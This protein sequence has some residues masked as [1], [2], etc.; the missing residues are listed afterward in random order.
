[1]PPSFFQ[2]GEQILNFQ[3]LVDQMGVNIGR[4]GQFTVADILGC[5][6]FA[7]IIHDR[8][9]IFRRAQQLGN[10]KID[11]DKPVKNQR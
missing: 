8:G 6:V 11:I 3:A 10:D 2:T 4:K 7:A 1:M 5:H 9:E